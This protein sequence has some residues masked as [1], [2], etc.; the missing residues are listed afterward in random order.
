MVALNTCNVVSSMVVLKPQIQ[1]W[2]ETKQKLKKS[3]ILLTGNKIC[4]MNKLRNEVQ[5]AKYRVS[6]EE[7]T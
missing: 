4:G 2:W 5:E 3:Q 7:R 6:Q 1:M